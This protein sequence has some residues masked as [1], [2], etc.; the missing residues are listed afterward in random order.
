MTYFLNFKYV[1]LSSFLIH[2][3]TPYL[4]QQKYKES[5]FPPALHNT[6]TKSY[7]FSSLTWVYIH[8]IHPLQKN[9]LFSPCHLLIW[10]Y[11]FCI[12]D[13]YHRWNE[14]DR[15]LITKTSHCYMYTVFPILVLN[16]YIV[17]SWSYLSRLAK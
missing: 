3:F 11:S 10:Q 5:V 16:Q 15:K 8:F 1:F 6:S 12:D 14:S 7:L 2:I 17:H 13:F 4:F 9:C